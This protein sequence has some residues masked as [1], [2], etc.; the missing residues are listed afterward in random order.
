MKACYV[1]LSMLLWS[2]IGCAD[3]AIHQEK[4]PAL[5]GTWKLL[6]GTTIHGTDTVVTDYTAGKEMIKIITPTHFAFLLHDLNKGKDST[7][8]YTAGGGRVKI[9]DSTY[10]EYLDYFNLREWEGGTF[11][12]KY[13]ISGDT[14]FTSALEKVEAL[15]V[16]HLNLEKLVRVK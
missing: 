7:A 2:L 15:G 10:T 8:M 14:L 16:E 5:A 9:T 11:E 3:A 1:F 4:E 6:T 13:N 12:L